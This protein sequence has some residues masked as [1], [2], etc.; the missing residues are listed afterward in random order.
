[1][2]ERNKVII[3]RLSWLFIVILIIFLPIIINGIKPKLDIV[4]DEGYV[5]DYYS[6]LNETSVTIY[7]TFN[8][9][10]NSGYAT[11]KYYDSSNHL[12]ETKR[13]Y[14]TA[15]G[16]KVAKSFLL[17]VDGEVASYEIV[18]FEFD[19]AFT[20]EWIYSFFLPAIL[21]FIA[22]LLICYREYNYNGKKL[23]VYAGWYHHT[24]R[25]D[26]VKCDEHNTVISFT[27]LKL[28]TTLDDGTKLEATISLTNRVAL[29]INDKL[30]TR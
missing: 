2:N 1:M 14:F 4:D 15:Y 18:S 6:S 26:G 17:Y 13:T 29:K 24:L 9:E 27:P 21:M 16:E 10:V 28:S 11:V 25:V 22:S 8:R 3:H 19:T 7:I 20:S 12:L 23:S 30:V 5:N